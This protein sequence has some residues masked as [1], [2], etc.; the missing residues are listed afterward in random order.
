MTDHARTP[1]PDIEIRLLRLGEAGELA[2]LLAAY[3]RSLFRDDIGAPDT[4][5]A[6]QLLQDRTAEV[7][8]ARLDGELVGFIVFYDIPDLWTGMRSGLADHIYVAQEHRR[9]GIAKAMIDLLGEEADPRGWSKLVLHAPRNP[10]AGRQLYER[11]AAPADWKSF[12][13]RFSDRSLPPH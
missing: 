10:D 6:E 8:G 3:N 4:A 9:K 7:L 1:S 13:V 2:P 5:Y 12:V 11:V